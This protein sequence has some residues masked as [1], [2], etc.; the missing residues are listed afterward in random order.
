[1]RFHRNIASFWGVGY[2]PVAPGTA[3]A[4]VGAILFYLLHWG[5]IALEIDQA[6]SI[7]S[8]LLLIIVT[9]LIA[10]RS[11]N[12]L[13]SEWEHDASQ[14]VVDEVVGVWISLLFIPFNWVY[15]LIGFGLFRFF[16]IA[17]PLGIKKVDKLNSEWSVML[18]DILAGV[19]ANICF[20]LYFIIF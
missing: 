17:K 1:M 6:F 9:T 4:F 18:D 12:K 8:S 3:G 13:K 20:Q 7:A 5:F 19:Y 14:I 10:N 2:F 15:Y 16:D 11:I